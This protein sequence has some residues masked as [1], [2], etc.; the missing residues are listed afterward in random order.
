ML[1]FNHCCL[2]LLTYTLT[3][4]FCPLVSADSEI[5]WNTFLGSSSIDD[6]YCVVTDNSGNLY[7]TGISDASWGS[8]INPPSGGEDAFVAKLDSSGGLQWNTFL[9][10]S[11]WD[12]GHYVTVDINGNLYVTGE[13]WRN[14]LGLAHQSP[15]RGMGRLCGQNL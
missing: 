9:G 5:S 7:V 12:T 4:V 6:G 3:L 10:S 15:C 2:A 1:R 14:K 8:P 13:S 11:N